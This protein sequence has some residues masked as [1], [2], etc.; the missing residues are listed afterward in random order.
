MENPT[1]GE[2]AIMIKDVAGDI[3]EIKAQT[4]KTNG[5]VSRLEDWKNLLT[6][7]LI[8]MNIICVPVF[9][10]IIYKWINEK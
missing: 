10:A 3:G 1:N 7:G 4:T 5:R 2:L 9:L 6:G 8:F